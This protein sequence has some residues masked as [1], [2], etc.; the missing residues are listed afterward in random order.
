MLKKT[1][2]Y[3]DFN[4]EEQTEDFYFNLT[5]AE[6][7]ETEL[8]AGGDG[9]N[10]QLQRIIASKDGKGVI[11]A[12]K[13]IVR[14][15][16][17]KRSEDGKRFIKSEALSDEFESTGAYDVLFIELVTDAEASA[18]FMNAIAPAELAQAAQAEAAKQDLTP[19]ERS[20]AQMQGYLKKGEGKPSNVSTGQ[21][22]LSTLSREQLEALVNQRGLEGQ[23]ISTEG[24]AGGE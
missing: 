15:A 24:S 19:R 17:G 22:D 10:A 5:K 20:E 13:Q 2:T 8:S 14:K 9:F 23:I 12:T 4:G 16:Y 11:D 18:A 21:P 7:V 6:L 1:I 3:T